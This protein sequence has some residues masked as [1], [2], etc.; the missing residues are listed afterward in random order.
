MM[1][2][3]APR[4]KGKAAIPLHEVLKRI[5]PNVQ[6]ERQFEWLFLPKAEELLPAEAAIQIKL[7][8][9]C[10][11]TR[12]RHPRK[13]TCDPDE[14]FSDVRNQGRTRRLELDFYLPSLNIAI[15]FDERQHFTAERQTALNA[16]P[17]LAFPFELARWASLCSDRV[18]DYDPPG[19][20]WHRAFRDSVRDIRAREHNIPLL[21][22]YYADFNSRVLSSSDGERAVAAALQQAQRGTFD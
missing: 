16:Y 13:S 6:C 7:V 8:E 20:D 18:I 19:R 17:D 15:E 21:R 10:R 12:H 9:H 2:S 11:D 5:D 1:Q 22:L 14:L 4:P 3:C